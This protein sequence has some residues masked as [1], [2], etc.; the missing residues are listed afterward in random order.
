MLLLVIRFFA[1][2]CSMQPEAYLLL[3]ESAHMAA[4]HIEGGDRFHA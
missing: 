2:T 3:L 4:K 1:D